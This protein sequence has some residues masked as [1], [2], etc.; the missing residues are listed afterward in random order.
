MKRI[1]FALFSALAIAQTALVPAATVCPSGQQTIAT[2][3]GTVGTAYALLSFS[4][5]QLDATVKINAATTPPTVTSNVP[6]SGVITPGSV[7]G[8]VILFPTAAG[9]GTTI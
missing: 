1:L 6:T 9:P 5:Q 3:T 8:T 2:Q 4:C 7:P